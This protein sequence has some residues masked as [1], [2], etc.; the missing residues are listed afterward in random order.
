MKT[1]KFLSA[2]Q[3]L[4]ENKGTINKCLV[5]FKNTINMAK[6]EP[7]AVWC[8]ELLN[9]YDSNKA[10]NAAYYNKIREFGKIGDTRVIK[11][12]TT[13]YHS[14]IKCSEYTIFRFFWSQYSN[15][16]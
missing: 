9:K 16:K 10:L 14:I 8:R 6:D 2:W 7:F 4:S 12:G 1:N 15:G 5:D 11:R 3:N 13:E